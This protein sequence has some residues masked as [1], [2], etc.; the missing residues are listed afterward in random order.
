MG[1][2][3]CTAA[4]PWQWVARREHV[5][6]AGGLPTVILEAN[7]ADDVSILVIDRVLQ[8]APG[9]WIEVCVHRV[10][11]SASCQWFR[12]APKMMHVAAPYL[13]NSAPPP[14]QS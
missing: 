10:G 9:I 2:V 7:V 13:C 8:C 5:P 14:K 4:V 1:D 11:R 12:V 3:R 6:V